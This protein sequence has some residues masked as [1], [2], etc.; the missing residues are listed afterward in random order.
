MQQIGVTPEQIIA[1][2]A[3]LGILIILISL[4]MWIPEWIDGQIKHKRKTRRNEK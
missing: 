3:G 2:Y 4:A 1:F